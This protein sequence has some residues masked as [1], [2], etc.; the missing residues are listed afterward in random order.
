MRVP[1]SFRKR[2]SRPPRT[3]QPSPDLVDQLAAQ[4]SVSTARLEADRQQLRATL[5][6][7]DHVMMPMVLKLRPKVRVREVR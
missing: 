3:Y 4:Q 5:T 1:F 2:V 6:S 7:A